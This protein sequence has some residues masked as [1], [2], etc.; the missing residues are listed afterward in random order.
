MQYFTAKIL[1]IIL[2]T[3]ARRKFSDSKKYLKNYGKNTT[4][5]VKLTWEYRQYTAHKIDVHN[6]WFVQDHSKFPDKLRIPSIVLQH[7][8]L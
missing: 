1:Y 8:G 7:S 6:L 5:K 4:A 3:V 2:W